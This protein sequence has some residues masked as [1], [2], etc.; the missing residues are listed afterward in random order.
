M[1]V[2]DGILIRSLR[3]I[4]W[5]LLLLFLSVSVSSALGRRR[6]CEAGVWCYCIAGC[7]MAMPILE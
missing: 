1:G 6:V 5:R 4:V 2:E 3:T 7:D